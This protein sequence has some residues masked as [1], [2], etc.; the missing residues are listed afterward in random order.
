MNCLR[1]ILSCDFSTRGHNLLT[2]RPDKSD[3]ARLIVAINHTNTLSICVSKLGNFGIPSSLCAPLKTG[4][5]CQ[6]IT[7]SEAKHL[8]DQ[9]TNVRCFQP[10]AAERL[11][12]VPRC[13]NDTVYGV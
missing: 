10:M 11:A 9:K 5:A 8:I 2:S 1:P 6:P 3:R 7:N 12:S 4:E 13:R